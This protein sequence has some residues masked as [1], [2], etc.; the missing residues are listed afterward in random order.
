M[1]DMPD[2]CSSLGLYRRIARILPGG[3]LFLAKKVDDLFLVFAL[4]DHPNIPL[5]LTRTAKTVLKLTL[6]LAGG[7]LTHFPVNYA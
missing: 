6:A 2:T 3:A 4:K 7:A 1:H 5:N